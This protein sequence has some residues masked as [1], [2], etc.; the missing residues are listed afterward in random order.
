MIHRSTTATA[1]AFA[2]LT[3]AACGGGSGGSGGTPPPPTQPSG[4]SATQYV[5]PV[6]NADFPDPGVV[7][8]SDGSY[9]AYATQTTG[10]HIQL[11]HSTD[12]VT[13]STPGEALPVRPT[14]ASQSQNFWAPDVALRENNTYVMYFSAEVD[15]DKRP[16]PGDDF[17]VG[18]ATATN[19]GGPFTDVGHPVVCGS[20]ATTIDP[21]GFDDPQ[22]GKRYLFWGSDFAPIQVQ[23]LSATDRSTF[24]AGTAPAPVVSPRAGQPYENLVEGAWMTYHAP[25]YYLFYSGGNCCVQFG[26]VA[27]AV[28]VARAPSPTGPF[29]FL[30]TSANGPTTPVLA[31]SAS[32]I[33]PGHNAVVMAGGAD[34]MLYHAIDVTHPTLPGGNVSRRALLLDKITYQANG[35]P[36]VGP[37]GMPTNT[38]QT[39]P[40]VP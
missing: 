12:L 36:V 31:A 23:E 28:M 33:G 8:A 2:V 22:T 9:Y 18:M 39:R 19:P 1:L 7:K 38:P 11:S 32:W 30:R 35:W 13:W 21:Q 5:N 14:W 16:S 29:E 15:P 20:G 37:A 24:A 3:L 4:P 27:Y 40:T 10:I 17:C 6:L 26:P 34:W 25:Y